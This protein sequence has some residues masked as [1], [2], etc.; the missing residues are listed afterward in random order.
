MDQDTPRFT[1]EG[2]GADERRKAI[3]IVIAVVVAFVILGFGSSLLGI[4]TDWLWYTHDAQQPE[5]FQ[6][7]VSSR[8]TMW[9][10]GFVVA[11]GVLFWNIRKATA[12]VLIYSEAPQNPQERLAQ[13]ALNMIERYGKPIGALISFFIALGFASYLGSRYQQYWYFTNSTEFGM[14]DPVWG[15]D[16]GFYVFQLPFLG[17]IT[18]FL[19]GLIF[20]T[21]LLAGGIYFAV[22][23]LAQVANIEIG[24]P[25]VRA[26]LSI[27]GGFFIIVFGLG[28]LL[29]PYEALTAY[30]SQFTGPGYTETQVLTLYFVMAGLAILVGIATL[31]NAQF[32]APYRVPAYGIGGLAVIGIIALGLYPA[33]LNNFVVDPNLLEYE[34]PYAERAITMTRYAYGIDGFEVR[35]TETV[36]KAPTIAAIDDASE[37]LR[38]MR[39]WDPNVLQD[40]ISNLQELK[41]YYNF[42]DVDIDRYD[43]DGEQ[44]VVMLS[45]RDI[46][47]SGLTQESQNWV[48]THLVYTHGFGITMNPVNDAQ[49]TGRPLFFVR[50]MPPQSQMGAPEIVQPRIYFSAYDQ[51]SRPRESYVVLKTNER[52]FDYPADVSAAQEDVFHRWDGERGVPVGGFLARLAYSLHFSDFPLLVSQAVRDESL[53]LYRR[54]IRDRAEQVYPM[55]S[56]DR[57]PYIV[58]RDGQINWILD[59]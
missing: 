2:G 28:M 54:D 37:T 10:I 39:L 43:I 14:N 25:A 27:L 5:V 9:I 33:A 58:V 41:P 46:Q 29:W 32:W 57:D 48:S 21:L 30:G 59:A 17:S 23:S 26:H 35:N 55:L 19:S 15:L 44:Q 36:R 40:G 22:R 8:V 11:F 3:R 12:T 42:S 4:Y 24:Q 52:E 53:L 47:P 34:T 56:F 50:D 1:V 20:I 13:E 6:R 16:V 49:A 31:L 51:G 18:G 7:I 45:P 38:N